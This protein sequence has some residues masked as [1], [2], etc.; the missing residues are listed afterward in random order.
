MDVPQTDET[1]KEGSSILNKVLKLMCPD[2]QAN[3]Y[4]KFAKIKS[5]KPVNYT[6]NMIKWHSAIESK[7]IL[8]EQKLPGSY[9]KLQVIIDYLDASLTVEVKS[10][11]AKIS[12]I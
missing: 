3:V 7:C 1:V 8:I 11:K 5:V 10:I 2:A 9:H 12:I 4:M 6:F